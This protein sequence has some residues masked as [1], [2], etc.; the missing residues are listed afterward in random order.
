MSTKYEDIPINVCITIN[1]LDSKYIF[2]E[3]ITIQP[4]LLIILRYGYFRF[5]GYCIILTKFY[6]I[7]YC[8]HEVPYLEI[9]KNKYQLGQMDFL[10]IFWK[11]FLA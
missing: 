5:P 9:H 7:I 2:I 8:V 6:V 11:I 4:I 1:L 3:I 10:K